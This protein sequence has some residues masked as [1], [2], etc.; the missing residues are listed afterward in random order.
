MDQTVETYIVQK[1]R[2]AGLPFPPQPAVEAAP[3]MPKD[4]TNLTPRE[5]MRYMDQ[6]SGLMAYA[7]AQ[8]AQSGAVT[9]AAKAKYKFLR[10]RRY[11]DLKAEQ[12]PGRTQKDIDNMI[13]CDA[14]LDALKREEVAAESYQKLVD[15]LFE[16]YT[17][18]Y[19]VFSRELTR[20]GQNGAQKES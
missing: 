18:R 16:G 4:V 12:V 10:A 17:A 19:N 1:A 5:L 6:F 8:A 11:L 7:G 13:D 20:R 9:A 15:S 14:S 2:N 3:E